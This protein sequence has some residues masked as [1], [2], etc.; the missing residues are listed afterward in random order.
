VADF[1]FGRV[2]DFGRTEEDLADLGR[3][4]RFFG[5]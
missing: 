2:A 4:V 1:D 3:I 5:D